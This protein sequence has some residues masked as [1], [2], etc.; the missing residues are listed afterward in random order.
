MRQAAIG[1]GGLLYM[2]MPLSIRQV[3][4]LEDFT[5]PLVVM[6]GSLPPHV[7][8]L[9]IHL[10]TVSVDN[11]SGAREV[12][13]SLLKAGHRQLALINGPPEAR[14]AWERESGFIGALK[15]FGLSYDPQSSIQG[16]FHYET[17]TGGWEQLKH[18]PIRPTAIVCGNDEIS[19]GL[20]EALRKDGLRCPEDVSVVGF[21]DSVWA[22]RVTPALTTVRQPIS[23]L[24]HLAVELLATRLQDPGDVPVEH[25]VF[26]PEIVTRQS[27]APP[28]A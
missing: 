25:R 15:E 6:G 4:K 3:V 17:G 2:A 21:D 23:Q 19:F 5:R 20:M 16:A 7:D 27:T 22:G 11:Q 8:L 1:A 24:G 26:P 13:L 12:T 14:D 9:D 18:K 28:R 10:N